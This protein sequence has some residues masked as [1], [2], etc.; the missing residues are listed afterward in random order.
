MRKQFDVILK[1]ITMC[2]SEFVLFTLAWTAV[3][4]VTGILRVKRCPVDAVVIILV[5]TI[6]TSVLYSASYTSYYNKALRA[7]VRFGKQKY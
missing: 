6:V 3:Y 7:K 4:V 5:H 2:V 1:T